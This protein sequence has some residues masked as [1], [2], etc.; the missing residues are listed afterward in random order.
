MFLLSRGKDK[1]FSIAR[2]NVRILAFSSAAFFLMT[3]LPSF[4]AD[5]PK[6]DSST[7]TDAGTASRS[8]PEIQNDIFLAKPDKEL[9][10]GFD[11]LPKEVRSLLE[12]KELDYYIFLIAD[13]K[14]YYWGE[15][16]KY[17]GKSAVDTHLAAGVN[18][19]V[20]RRSSAGS[21][22]TVSWHKLIT[23]QGGSHDPAGGKMITPD[24]DDCQMVILFLRGK[25]PEP[26]ENG[27]TGFFV[28]DK[29]TEYACRLYT[30]Q[31]FDKL[32]RRSDGAGDSISFKDFDLE[33]MPED[34]MVRD[35]LLF[36][37]VTR[38]FL[39]PNITIHPPGM[40][41]HYTDEYESYLESCSAYVEQLQKL[42]RSIGKKVVYQDVVQEHGIPMDNFYP[43]AAPKEK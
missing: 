15:A 19:S 28:P 13:S 26:R 35:D 2:N 36:L 21:V 22:Y 31:A 29:T 18:R 20:V 30:K 25:K 38:A 7:K 1:S 43:H 3:I 23:E 14:L 32:V 11:D 33:F 40:L 37:L 10:I 42:R 24:A 27:K 41:V 8:K 4:C 16:M 6:E 39:R 9:A 5:I 34:K 17:P 12:D